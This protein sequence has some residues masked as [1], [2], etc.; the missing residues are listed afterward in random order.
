MIRRS[1]R[2][3]YL[4]G[5][6]RSTDL[7]GGGEGGAEQEEGGSRSRSGCL[8][9]PSGGETLTNSITDERGG[10]AGSGGAV[11]KSYETWVGL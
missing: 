1:F 4:F 6:G 3:G 11:G 9:G 8:R 7:L 10:R 5:G 2:V